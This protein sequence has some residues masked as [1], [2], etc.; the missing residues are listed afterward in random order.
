GGPGWGAEGPRP[1]LLR[2]QLR[3]DHLLTAGRVIARLQGVELLFGVSRKLRLQPVIDLG[4]REAP[5]AG[6]FT[7]RQL[8]TAGQLADLALIAPEVIG[9]L[10]QVHHLV[11]H[12]QSPICDFRSLR[13]FRSL[14]ALAAGRWQ[15]WQVEALAAL[16]ELALRLRLLAEAP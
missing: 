4:A 14:S 5:L 9:Q 12:A 16:E 10:L 3:H 8:A 11:A 1:A 6:N 15:P 2:Q 13:D 7:P